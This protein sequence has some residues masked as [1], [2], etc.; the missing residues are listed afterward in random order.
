MYALKERSYEIHAQDNNSSAFALL[1]PLH[2][3][4]AV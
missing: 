1:L 4:Y 3:I 2:I